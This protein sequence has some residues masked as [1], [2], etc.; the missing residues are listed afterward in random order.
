MYM[1]AHN[2]LL[3]ADKT[4]S[5]VVEL[6]Y[7]GNSDNNQEAFFERMN[8]DLSDFDFQ[9]L[10]KDSNVLSVNMEKSAY[11]YVAENQINQSL[12]DINNY[13]IIEVFNI[14]PYDDTLY[15]AIVSKVYF[16]KTMRENTYVILNS[17]NEYGEAAG[18]NF[19]QGH[20]YLIIGS[21][22]DGKTL[23]LLLHRKFQMV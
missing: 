4:F 6:S 1:S 2:M 20:K 5:T 14:K 17:L 10:M 22:A 12:S 13:V 3:D 21:L 18:Y 11:A 16:G 9:K 7:L 15:Q 19:V 23:C 8:K